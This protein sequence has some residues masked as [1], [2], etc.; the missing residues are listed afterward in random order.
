MKWQTIAMILVFAGAV[1]FIWNSQCQSDPYQAPVISSGSEYA[2]KVKEA[3]D[4]S[5]IPLSKFDSGE[6][7]TP[8]DIDQLKRGAALTKGLIG[9]RPEAIT[10]F[11]GLSK[12]YLALG[13]NG[14]AHQWAQDG[15]GT[16]PLSAPDQRLKIVEAELHWISSRALEKERMYDKAEIEATYA[17]TLLDGNKA[18]A[19][20]YQEMYQADDAYGRALA[21]YMAQLASIKLQLV[22]QNYDGSEYTEQQIKD[23]KAERMKSVHD[24]VRAALLLDPDHPRAKQLDMLLRTSRNG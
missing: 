20:A 12:S 8:E 17:V 21:T 14:Q 1:G 11:V 19:K 4:L 22:Q 6:K 5:L 15:I 7:L 24:L 2:V 16:I 13:E 23:F 10:L 9:F 18:V 3:E